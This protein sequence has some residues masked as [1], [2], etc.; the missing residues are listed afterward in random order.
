MAIGSYTTL[1]QCNGRLATSVVLPPLGMVQS[2]VAC[3][4]V[5]DDLVRIEAALKNVQ[6]AAL[7]T[8]LQYLW[9]ETTWSL[10]ALERCAW[11]G[12]SDRRSGNV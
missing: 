3:V 9:D 1:R 12:R 5:K 4:T 6:S 8:G 7:T 11:R 2:V 10:E